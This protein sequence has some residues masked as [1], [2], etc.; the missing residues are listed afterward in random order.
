MNLFLTRLV[1]NAVVCFNTVKYATR[2]HS[3]EPGHTGTRIELN[4]AEVRRTDMEGCVSGLTAIVSVCGLGSE[5]ELSP[6][7]VPV[8][9]CSCHF[10]AV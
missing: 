4:P 8:S 2:Y 6:A 1:N 7:S 9:Q 5:L 3:Y 10:P